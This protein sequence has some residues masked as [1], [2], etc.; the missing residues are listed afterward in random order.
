MA[1]PV[2]QH[3]EAV[4]GGDRVNPRQ[5]R[6]APSPAVE[7]PAYPHED[8]LGRVFGLGRIA[9]ELQAPAKDGRTELPVERLD[10]LRVD[11]HLP[12]DVTPRSKNLGSFSSERR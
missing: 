1:A 6:L 9:Q 12:A 11:G 2:A 4:A 10:L 8:L 5:R 7:V 3:R